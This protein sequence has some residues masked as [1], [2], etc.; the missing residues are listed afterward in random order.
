[1]TSKAVSLTLLMAL[2]TLVGCSPKHTAIEGSW[3]IDMAQ[4][5]DQAKSI[6]ASSTFVQGVQDTFADARLTID[7]HELK[8]SIAGTNGSAANAYKVLSK[9]GDCLVLDIKGAHGESRYCVTG[10]RLEIHDS[11]TPL[12][13]VFKKS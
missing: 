1:M 7:G 10:S 4:T 5:L 2:T 3:T 9:E 8:M 13:V 11:T 6:G 12:V